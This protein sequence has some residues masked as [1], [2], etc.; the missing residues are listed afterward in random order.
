MSDNKSSHHLDEA[1]N[2]AALEYHAQPVPGKI[3]VALTKSTRTQKDL[4]LAYTPGVAE[5]VRRIAEN[6]ED[7]R[8]KIRQCCF[9]KGFDLCN[10]CTDFPC[11]LLK[12]NPGVIRFHC[13]E[14]LAE[15]KEKGIR[16]WIDKQMART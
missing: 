4:A 1:I 14:N 12:N 7:D 2:Q 10:E 3:S 15:I 8:C 9:R 11:D 5:P 13:I 16:Y 6:P